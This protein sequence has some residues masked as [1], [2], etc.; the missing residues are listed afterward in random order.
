MD[1]A[2]PTVTAQLAL[3]L[4]IGAAGALTSALLPA[5]DPDAFWHLAVG[6]EVL[7]GGGPPRTDAYS[8]TAANVAVASDQWLGQALFALAY[9]TAGWKGVV[10]LRALAGGLVLA[11]TALAALR[12]TGRPIVAVLATVP[13]LLLLRAVWTERPQLLALVCFA[14]LVLLLRSAVRGEVRALWAC[15]PLLLVWANVHGSFALGLAMVAAVALALRR[16]GALLA[17]GA[18]VLATLATPTLAGS[19]TAPSGHLLAPPRY[20]QE[21]VV[22]D[23]LTPSGVVLALTLAAILVTALLG[24]AA[25]REALI[26]VPAV[27]IALSAARHAMFLAI[28]AAPFLAAGAPDA[29]RWLADRVG[30]PLRAGAPSRPARSAATA[31]SAA[32]AIVLCVAA[33]AVAPA[34]PDLGAYPVAAVRA[35]EPG[36]GLFNEYD[37]GGFLIWHAPATKVFVDGRLTPY[38]PRVIDDYTTIS[39]AHPGWRETIARLG[40]RQ[41]LVRPRSGVAVRAR[42]LGWREAAAGPGFVLFDVPR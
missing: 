16:A 36:A 38:L 17:L 12:E 14:A 5:G 34:D 4:A 32:I 9:E 19:Y 20:L 30:L 39:E 1:P 15:A 33:V 2:R 27:L 21:W 37:W 13:S 35:L 24:G 10:A 11:L 29:L 28:A 42:E 40:V 6:R 26:L 31:A 41:V 7:H 23:L 8:W 3:A 25:P 18:C 22:P